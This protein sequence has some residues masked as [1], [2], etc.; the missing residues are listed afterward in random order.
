MVIKLS[1]HRRIGKGCIFIARDIDSSPIMKQPPV[2]REVWFYILRKVSYKDIEKFKRGQGFF[3]IPKIQNDLSWKVGNSIRTYSYKQIQQSIRRLAEG[4]NITS[5]KGKTGIIITVC[6]YDEYQNMESYERY[7]KMSPKDS[8][9]QLS[10]INRQEGKIRKKL[11]ADSDESANL[12]FIDFYLTKSGKK[13]TG[14]RLVAF[15]EFWSCYNFKR[16][17]AA[18]ADAWLKI[19][20]L[21]RSIMSQILSA[22]KNEAKRRVDL[23][24]KGQS[25]KWAQGWI[26]ERRWEDE[27]YQ[28]QVESLPKRKSIE[29]RREEEKEFFLNREM[30]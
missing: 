15:N 22:A 12:E 11:I 23:V 1:D 17:K 14:K 26:S 3:Q 7:N 16:G 18:A 5:R 13:L 30:P 20:V 19:P 2:T 27:A 4:H 28:P 9:G 24:A 10:Y 29:A 21:N 6:N 25:P 8:E